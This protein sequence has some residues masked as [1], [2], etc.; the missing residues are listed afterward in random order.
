VSVP[1]SAGLAGTI[2]NGGSGGS[3]TTTT[4]AP[5]ATSTPTTTP[6]ASTTVPPSSG[7]RQDLLN[8]ASAAYDQA[9]AA[10]KAGDFTQYAQLIQQVGTLLKQA[11][12]AT[13]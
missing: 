11:Q 1:C 13:K 6:P 10:L 9:Q 4:T 12:A 7:S 5:P 2:G 3:G 8:Q